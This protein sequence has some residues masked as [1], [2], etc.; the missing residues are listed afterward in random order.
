MPRVNCSEGGEMKSNGAGGQLVD[1]L[2]SRNARSEKTLAGR[3]QCKIEQAILLKGKR[4]EASKIRGER[5]GALLARV[6]RVRSEGAHFELNA[7]RC[8]R[9]K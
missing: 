8:R 3:A 9:D 4:G 7:D 1:L 6:E 2:C 5:P